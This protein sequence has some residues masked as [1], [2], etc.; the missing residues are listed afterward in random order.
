MLA[1]RRMAARAHG[2]EHLFAS[3]S[4]EDAESLASTSEEEEDR[5]EGVLARKAAAQV[6]GNLEEE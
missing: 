4:E 6:L 2:V 3:S 5:L 1:E